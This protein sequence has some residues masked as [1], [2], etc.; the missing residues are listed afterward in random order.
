[1][2]GNLQAEGSDNTFLGQEWWR[3]HAFNPSTQEAA[4]GGS[5]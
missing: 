4:T 1:M 2:D 3:A 5:L